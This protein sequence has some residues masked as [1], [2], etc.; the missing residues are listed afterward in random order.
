MQ[1]SLDERC[2]ELLIELGLSR[3]NETITAVPLTGGV[4]SD[5]AMVTVGEQKFC[6]KFALPKLKVAA[7]WFAPVHRNAAEFAWLEVAAR[8]APASAVKLSPS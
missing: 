4:A 1:T 2:R 3:P 8:I 7:D 5:I 6:V